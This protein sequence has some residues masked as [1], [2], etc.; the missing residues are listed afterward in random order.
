ML[1]QYGVMR[2]NLQKALNGLQ[3]IPI[4]IRPVFVTAN[5]LAPER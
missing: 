5:E 2:P 1:D 3:G 4:D